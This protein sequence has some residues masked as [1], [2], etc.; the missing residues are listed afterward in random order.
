ME[1]RRYHSESNQAFF[2]TKTPGHYPGVP[3]L[4]LLTHLT[5]H[6]N[7]IDTTK[8]TT[9]PTIAK[10]TV[11]K[12]SAS[13][14]VEITATSVPPVVPALVPLSITTSF[15][16]VFCIC[17]QLT[18]CSYYPSGNCGITRNSNQCSR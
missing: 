2:I 3:F 16:R 7:T 9:A 6:C 10:I 14:I 8:L 18:Y 4:L 13:L 1:V 17:C 11:F 15:F 12:I 5:N